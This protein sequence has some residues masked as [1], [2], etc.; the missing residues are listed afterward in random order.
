MTGE[1]TAFP[2]TT[3][4]STELP[5]STALDVVTHLIG[6]EGTENVR[7]SKAQIGQGL[8]K[9]ST[10]GGFCNESGVADVY[11]FEPISGRE[12]IITLE[13][14]MRFYGE[15]T[16]PNTGAST[17]AVH[18][19]AAAPIVDKG[20]VALTT[21]ALSGNFEVEYDL[22]NTRFTL[23]TSGT[24][25][26]EN[27]TGINNIVSFTSSGTYTKPANLKSVKITVIGGGGGGG[28]AA[29]NA[30]AGG[31]G[32]GGGS[33][34]LI[35]AATLSASETVTI[36]SGGSGGSTAGGDGGAAGTSSFGSFASATGGVGGRGGTGASVANGVLGGVGSGGTVNFAGGSGGAASGLMA[37][38]GGDSFFGGGGRAESSTTTDI[39]GKSSGA[40][41]AGCR[42]WGTTARVGGVGIS[43]V[44][45]VEEFF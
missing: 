26:D 35:D 44:V 13:D 43:G 20:G 15:T 3:R 42:G 29:A 37:G 28:G 38:K 5:T 40:G 1:I 45:I 39:G 6:Y 4:K 30:I 41:G 19:L 9:Y 16:N 18:G 34:V 10:N 14:G 36:G 27:A 23:I 8:T 2:I 33:I 32:A 24:A 17:I 7:V 21:G 11:V 31:G 12:R 22:S 25:S